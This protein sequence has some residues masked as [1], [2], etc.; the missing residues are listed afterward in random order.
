ME[1]RACVGMVPCILD[2]PAHTAKRC[3]PST[4]VTSSAGDGQVELLPC[5]TSGRLFA[6]D[7]SGEVPHLAELR[8]QLRQEANESR[9]FLAAREREEVHHG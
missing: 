7:S 4:E 1:L 6:G 5:Q 8:E 3:F 2:L 9:S